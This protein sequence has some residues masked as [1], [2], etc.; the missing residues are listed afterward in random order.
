MRALLGLLT[1]RHAAWTLTWIFVVVTLVVVTLPTYASTYPDD[2][3]R[4]AAVKLAQSNGATTLLYG[5]LPGPGSP[6]QLFVWEIGTFVTL[7]VAVLGLLMAVRLT[8]AAEQQGTI[9]IV[10]AAGLGRL[11]PLTATLVLLTVVSALLG[12]ASA[13]A[14]GFRAGRVAGIDWAGSLAFGSVV[15]LTFLLIALIAVVAAQLVPTPWSARVTTAL[16]L[17]G[18]FAL[19]AIADTQRHPWLNWV[20]PF[21]LRATAA[22]FTSK[23]ILPLVVALCVAVLL[24]VLAVALERSR[25]LGPSIV[26]VST[27]RVHHS[28]VSSPLGFAWR[29][30]R[31][32]TFWWVAGIATGGTLFNAMGSSVVKT[33]RQGGLSGGFLGAQLAGADPVSAYFAYTGTVV[34]TVVVASAILAMLEAVTEERNGAGEYLRAT[35]AS[36]ARVLTGHLEVALIG[37]ALALAFTAALIAIVAPHTLGGHGVSGE[38]FG[39]VIGQWSGVLVLV[40]PVVLLTGWAPRMAWL[41]WIPWAASVTLALLGTLLGIPQA[42]IDLG[43]L[44]PAHGILTPLARIGL[45]AVRRR[46]LALG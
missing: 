17:T 13:A 30:G 45:W 5:Q 27:S 33:A 23:R 4:L 21:G 38:A 31:A 43:P 15:T 9:E 1:R 37:S 28:R 29:L 42:I 20:T 24:A 10:R 14:A 46:D 26:R 2:A 44:N 36:P 32:T 8:R 41:G 35:G 11:A 18:C 3:A 34:A 12:L 25:E 6:A 7:L 22:P 40:G 39:Q 19:R 16:V